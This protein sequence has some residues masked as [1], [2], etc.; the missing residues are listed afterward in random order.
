MIALDQRQ[1]PYVVVQGT[2]ATYSQFVLLYPRYP[3]YTRPL[4]FMGCQEALETLPDKAP[5]NPAPMRDLGAPMIDNVVPRFTIIIETKRPSCRNSTS[6]F[7]YV[8]I[9]SF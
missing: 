2:I 5:S 4:I 3:C 7:H 8:R 9:D 6:I 1:R